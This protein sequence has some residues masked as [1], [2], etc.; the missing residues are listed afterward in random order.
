MNGA[1]EE[2]EDEVFVNPTLKGPNKK[3]NTRQ[4]KVIPALNN[5]HHKPVQQFYSL[6]TTHLKTTQLCETMSSHQPDNK[7]TLLSTS[8]PDSYTHAVTLTRSHS[9]SPSPRNDPKKKLKAKTLDPR[10]IQDELKRTTSANSV[11]ISFDTTHNISSPVHRLP[12]PIPSTPHRGHTSGLHRGRAFKRISVKDLR[13]ID[14]YYDVSYY[15]VSEMN[16][17]S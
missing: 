11:F 15:H 10:V 14:G 3:S 7:Q 9:K 13:D 16:Q 8:L 17:P 1:G 4:M 5:N 12:D 2:E 6:N